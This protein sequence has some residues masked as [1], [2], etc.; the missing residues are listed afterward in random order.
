MKQNLQVLLITHLKGLHALVKDVERV[1]LCHPN[2]IFL[3]G[4]K[5]HFFEQL[6]PRK[7]PKLKFK[8]GLK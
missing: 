5:K 2:F 3:L 4:K 7:Y 6:D 1:L 8:Q